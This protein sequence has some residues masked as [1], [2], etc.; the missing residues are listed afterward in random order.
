MS[1]VANWSDPPAEFAIHGPFAAGTTG[2]TRMPG[3]PPTSWL[4]R[5][6]DSGRAYTIEA[7]SFPDE[8][9]LLFHWRFDELSEHRTRLTQRIELLGKNAFAY[10]DRIREAFEPNLEP[11]L[12]RIAEKMAQAASRAG[13][14]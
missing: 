11:G 10:A 7:A 6:V 5:E 1:T 4:I 8:T 2:S 14:P 12:Q 3:Q 9:Q 13:S